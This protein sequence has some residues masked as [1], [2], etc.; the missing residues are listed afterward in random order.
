M[1]TKQCVSSKKMIPHSNVPQKNNLDGTQDQV[2]KIAI[3][4][5]FKELKWGKELSPK[6]MTG[7][8]KQMVE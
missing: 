5:M 4:D 8:H 1:K 7:K 3:L 6:M 2:L